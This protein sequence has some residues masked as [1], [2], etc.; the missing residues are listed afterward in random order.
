MD[1]KFNEITLKVKKQEITI[2]NG[3]CVTQFRVFVGDSHISTYYK[4]S[5]THGMIYYETCYDT[6]IEPV[7][8]LLSFCGEM[9][10]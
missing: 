4:I 9:K 7:N 1:D 6:L 8:F 5:D 2:I 3:F 10:H